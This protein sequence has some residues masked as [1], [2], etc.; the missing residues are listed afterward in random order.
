MNLGNLMRI[1]NAFD[2]SFFFSIIA[3]VKLSDA[4]S[5]T[6]LRKAPC[7]SMRFGPPTSFAC[8]SDAGWWA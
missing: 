5:D 6:S 8:R 3:Q 2:A 1:A 4:Q 7:R